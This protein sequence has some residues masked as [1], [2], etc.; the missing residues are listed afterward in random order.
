MK[1]P[2][3][4]LESLLRETPA[5]ASVRQQYAFDESA[6]GRRRI[7]IFGAGR[8]GRL[9]LQGLFGT[10]LEPVAI[11]DNNPS[12]WGKVPDVLPGLSP[13]DH[14]NNPSQDAPFVVAVWH[15]SRS[16]LMSALLDQ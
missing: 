12:T 13:R 2:G 5:A 7:V 4:Q 1:S 11:T 6:A 14:A 16:P 8:L 10:D 15:P 3:Q 9:V